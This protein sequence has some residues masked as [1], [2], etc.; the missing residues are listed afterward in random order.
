MAKFLRPYNDFWITDLKSTLDIMERHTQAGFPPIPENIVRLQLFL[1]FDFLYQKGFIA[2]RLAA[3]AQDL[4]PELS[5]RN[6][7]LT[8]DGY[9]FSQKYLP[10]WQDRLYKFT[11]EA[12]ELRFLEK[13]YQQYIK[14]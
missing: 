5:L 10:M 14:Q 2:D 7:H 11:T 8:E 4:K 9:Y 3:S 13:W 1:F 6:Q 12:K